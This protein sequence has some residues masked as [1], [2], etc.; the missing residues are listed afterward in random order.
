[1]SK[2]GLPSK[3]GSGLAGFAVPVGSGWVGCTAAEKSSVFQRK[4]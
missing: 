4:K 2:L 1:M 3:V